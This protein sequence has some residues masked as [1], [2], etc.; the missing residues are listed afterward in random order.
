[1]LIHL[2]NNTSYVRVLREIESVESAVAST[3]RDSGSVDGSR[4]DDAADFADG[5]SESD[6]FAGGFRGAI[7]RNRSPDHEIVE[8][9]LVEADFLARA[10]AVQEGTASPVDVSD[11]VR[12]ADA[13]GSFPKSI[14]VFVFVSSERRRY[15][16]C[17]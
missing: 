6:R 16:A 3:G 1:M 5:N 2:L 15:A 10:A 4:R 12:S 11:G 8:L 7:E 13:G 9:L 17:R 14:A